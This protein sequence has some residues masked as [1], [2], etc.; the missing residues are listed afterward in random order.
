MII[1]ANMNAIIASITDIENG[2]A[3]FTVHPRTAILF[4]GKTRLSLLL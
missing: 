3:K 4:G 1:T 2:F